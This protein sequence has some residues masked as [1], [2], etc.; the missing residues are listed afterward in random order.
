MPKHAI[1][2]N[3]RVAKLKTTEEKAEIIK[4]MKWRRRVRKG[5]DGDMEN[6]SIDAEGR[7]AGGDDV[8]AGAV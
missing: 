2:C 1:A 8:S 5:A 4:R 6:R 3:Q 7:E